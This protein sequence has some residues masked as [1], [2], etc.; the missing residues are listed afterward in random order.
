ME[1]V[2]VSLAEAEVTDGLGAK[3]GGGGF[4]RART[5]DAVSEDSEDSDYDDGRQSK[6]KKRKTNQKKQKKWRKLKKINRQKRNEKDFE[7]I[8]FNKRLIYDF[9]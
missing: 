9:L 7:C 8:E 4:A 1:L 6:S 5:D 3:R 2:D